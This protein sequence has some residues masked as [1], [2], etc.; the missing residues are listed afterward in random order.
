MP[1]LAHAAS[2]SPGTLL[3]IRNRCLER[4]ALQDRYVITVPEQVT[5][6]HTD[7]MQSVSGG[8]QNALLCYRTAVPLADQVKLECAAEDTSRHADLL[9]MPAVYCQ[10]RGTI[11]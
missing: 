3:R 11:S 5:G 10:L 8:S 9:A 2:G 1:P 6:R 7:T 4:V